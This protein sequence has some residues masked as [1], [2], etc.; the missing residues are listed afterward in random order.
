MSQVSSEGK[1]IRESVWEQ[2]LCIR[3][4][5]YKVFCQHNARYAVTQ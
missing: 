2:S 4:Y 1:L 3:M 5:S